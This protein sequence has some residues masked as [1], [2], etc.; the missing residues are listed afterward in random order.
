MWTGFNYLRAIS[1]RWKNRR[2]KDILCISPGD[3]M[4]SLQWTGNKHLT[5]LALIWN[6]N[7]PY[8]SPYISYGTSK[9][10]LSKYQDILFL[11]TTSLI[12]ITWMFEQ[13][14]KMKR[15]ISFSS[16]LQFKG[17]RHNK[18][19]GGG[20][21][22]SGTRKKRAQE[23]YEKRDFRGGGKRD[24]KTKCVIFGYRKR[25]KRHPP[26]PQEKKEGLV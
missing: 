26:P 9:E 13:V 15:E 7:S 19:W 11:V 22:G 18:W 24:K 14:V 8:C 21:G 6:A 23:M 25:A 5:L 10:N 17:W 1:G 3:S 16:L 2:A 20:G 12:L 4:S